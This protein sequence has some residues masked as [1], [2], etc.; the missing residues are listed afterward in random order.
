VVELLNR[1]LKIFFRGFLIGFLILACVPDVLCMAP[2]PIVY[3]AGDGSGDFNCDGKD[4]HIQI[5]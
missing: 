4:D 1:N 3:V 2:A 5:N